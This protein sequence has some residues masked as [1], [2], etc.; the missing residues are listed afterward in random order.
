MQQQE[1]QT[2]VKLLTTREVAA[3]S[4]FSTSYFEKKRVNGG[5]SEE[6]KSPPFIKIGARV[7]YPASAFEEWLASYK[8]QFNTAQS[9]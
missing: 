1:T 4:G 5:D 9:S 7:R 8:L 3:M 2:V 6:S